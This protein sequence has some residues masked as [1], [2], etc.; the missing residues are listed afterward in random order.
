[1]KEIWKPIGFDFVFTNKCR[2]EVS[3]WGRIRSFNKVSDGN[4]LKPSL[5]Q[6]YEVIRTKFYKPRSSKKQELFDTMKRELSE[7]Y[8]VRRRMAEQKEPLQEIEKITEIINTQKKDLSKK[9]QQDLKKRTI[10]HHF[11]IHREVATYFLPEKLPEQTVVAHLDYNKRNNRVE[12]LK[13]MTPEE[14]QIHQSKSP[15]VIAE[16]KRRK[17]AYKGRNKGH[18]LTSTQV[19]HIKIRLQKGKTAKQLAKQFKVSEMQIW[20]IKSGEN[21]GHIQVPEKN[22]TPA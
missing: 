12:N 13:W 14:N 6:G 11:L 7:W 9:M 18:K 4:I 8:R 22:Y 1:M 16:K 20:R 17:Y 10:N 15:N 19:M 21:W 3:N 5:T 2:F